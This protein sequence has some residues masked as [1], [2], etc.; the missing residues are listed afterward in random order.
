MIRPMAPRP[1]KS[2]RKGDTLVWLGR[3]LAL[4]EARRPCAAAAPPRDSRRKELHRLPLRPYNHPAA[5]LW[6]SPEP[7]HVRDQ[8]P[9][10]PCF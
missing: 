7:R 8:D 2:L 5:P 3:Q 6:A 9:G 10:V 1:L 4:Y